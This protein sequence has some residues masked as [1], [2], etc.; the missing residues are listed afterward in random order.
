MAAHCRRPAEV[1]WQRPDGTVIGGRTLILAIDTSAAQCAV[2]VVDGDRVAVRSVEMTRG[3]AEA[4]FPMIEEVLAELGASYADL[5]RVAVCTG[6]G[7]FTGLRVGISAARGLAL[8]R[9][10][11]AIGVTR[12]EA[13]AAGIGSPC[14]VRLP[15]RAG[16]V[17][18][19]DFG[20]DLNAAGEPRIEEGETAELLPDPVVIARLAALREARGRPAPLYLRD[21]DAALPREAPPVILDA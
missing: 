14:T 7:S 16:S 2:A 19:Q 5:D 1:E 20:A 3:H 9:G 17:F 4:L 18:V 21:A 8:G 12:F 13:I 6:P 10:I 11:P 15:G